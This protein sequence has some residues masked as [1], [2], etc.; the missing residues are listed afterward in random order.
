MPGWESLI[1]FVD[2]IP[3]YLSKFIGGSTRV[4]SQAGSNLTNPKFQLGAGLITAAVISGIA[5]RGEKLSSAS[6]VAGST[7]GFMAGEALGA[8]LGPA[9]AIIG[10][11]AGQ[12]IGEKIGKPMQKFTEFGRNLRRLETGGG[13][14]DSQLKWT[15]RQ[16][17]AAELGG[18]LMNARQILG[19][20]AAFMHQ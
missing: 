7:F 4:A 10:G 5:P 8:P 13:Y 6:A 9:G 12:M 18:S 19:R 16:R 1:P 15:M 3:V 11:I 17:A 2:D 14:Q 20:E